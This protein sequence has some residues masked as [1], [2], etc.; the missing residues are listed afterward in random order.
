MSSIAFIL[1]LIFGTTE[2]EEGGEEEGEDR[3]EE[4]LSWF[5]DL[6]FDLAV[7]SFSDLFLSEAFTGIG[8]L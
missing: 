8:E 3:E 1:I 5:W 6:C 7:G 4:G 2:E